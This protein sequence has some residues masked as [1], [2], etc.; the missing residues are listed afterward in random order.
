MNEQRS[1]PGLVALMLAALLAWPFAAQAQAPFVLPPLG[2]AGGPE[3]AQTAT[4][5]SAL[6]SG[7]TGISNAE[8]QAVAAPYLSSPIKIGRAHV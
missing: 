7:N 1:R 4:A 6:F 3:G 8:L 5:R 2:A